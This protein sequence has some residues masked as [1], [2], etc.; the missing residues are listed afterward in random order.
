MIIPGPASLATIACAL[1]V[2]VLLA[3][4]RAQRDALRF[5]AKPLA[6]ALFLVVAW[7]A[8]RGRP[9]TGFDACV[10][11]GLALGAAGD[12][13]L[14]WKR[15]FLPGLVAFLLGHLAYVAAVHERLPAGEWLGAAGALAIVPVVLSLAILA[16]LWPHLGAMRGPVIAY[17]AVI[18]AMV[19]AAIALGRADTGRS[20]QRFLAGAI[21]FF[22]SDVSVA[23]DK[24]VAESFANKAWGLPAYYAGQLL[25]AW[26]LSA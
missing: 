8:V 12:V 25:I 14:L 20:A 24:F 1:C 22:A 23:R 15:G 6:S 3:G 18:T 4:E 9:T 21:L 16:R 7:L 5:A 19:I 11:A 17:V 13:A 26:S 10:L 2:G